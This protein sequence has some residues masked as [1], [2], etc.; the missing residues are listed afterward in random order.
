VSRAE[1]QFATLRDSIQRAAKSTDDPFE[2]FNAAQG[3][4]AIRDPYPIFAE[5]RAAAPVHKIDMQAIAAAAPDGAP[6]G[7]SRMAPDGDLWL[8]V[9]YDAVEEVLRDG[10]RFN[11]SG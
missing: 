9:S 5:M 6:P 7:A 8:A 11:S 4:G 10:E 3:M 2:A 1:Q